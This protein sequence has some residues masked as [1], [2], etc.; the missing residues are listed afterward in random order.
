MDK[1]ITRTPSLASSNGSQPAAADAFYAMMAGE[2]VYAKPATL[3]QE[4]KSATPFSELSIDCSMRSASSHLGD[5]THGS[6]VDY[7]DVSI[8]SNLE[9]SFAD[10][11]FLVQCEASSQWRKQCE[12]TEEKTNVTDKVVDV[13]PPEDT[14]SC[15]SQVTQ[16]TAYTSDPERVSA[17]DLERAP[18]DSKSS[19]RSSDCGRRVSFDR[20]Q[21][22][23]FN[24]ILDVNPAVSSGPAIGIGWKIKSQKQMSVDDWELRKDMSHK[25][26]GQDL[27]LQRGTRESLLIDAGYSSKDLARATR[28]ILKWKNQ[29]KTTLNNLQAQPYEEALENAARKLK[30]LVK[31]SSAKSLMV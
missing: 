22:R 17:S 24:R 23:S 9:S 1:V 28:V 29:R 3:D 6:S 18:F 16:S 8:D 13:V 10:L 25:R 4:G 2:D 15:H 21:V 5:S 11:D 30:Q 7:D 19:R 27:V 14:Q 26:G 20:V 12:S 31:P